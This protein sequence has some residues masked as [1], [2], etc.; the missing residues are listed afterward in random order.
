MSRTREEKIIHSIKSMK[1]RNDVLTITR[2]KD[3]SVI[4]ERGKEII[5]LSPQELFV[6]WM[7]KEYG[8]E[9]WD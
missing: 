1:V 8:I 4:I 7:E 5:K 9:R 3:Y 2:F 6:N